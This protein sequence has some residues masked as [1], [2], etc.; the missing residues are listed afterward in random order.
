MRMRLPTSLKVALLAALLML[1]ANLAVIGFIRW[2]THD[3]SAALL[4]RQVAE[5]ASVLDDVYRTGGEAA[6]RRAI[7]DIL[8]ARDPQYVAAILGPGGRPL[9]GNVG[10]LIEPAERSAGFRDGRLVVVGAG[11]PVEAAF[12]LRPL[13]AG[14]WLLSG[15]SFGERLALQR[16]L[17]RSLLLALAIAVLLGLASG[18]VIARYVDRRVRGIALVADRIGHGDMSQRVPLSGSGDAFDGLAGQVNRMLDRIG[19]LMEELRLLTDCLAHD[20]RSPLGRLRAKV[21]AAIA[22]G[23]EGRRE[24]ALAGVVQEADSLMRILTT[25]LEIGRAEAMAPRNQFAWLDP[26]ELVAELAEMYEPI[27]EEAGASLILARDPVLLPLFGHRQL[28]AQ[29][30]SNL[31]DNALNYAPGG[32]LTL[33]ARA[34]EDSLSLGVA[35]RGPGIAPEDRAEARRQFGRLDEARAPGGAGLGLALVEAV[36]HLHQGRLALDDHVPGLVASLVLPIRS[37]AA[38]RSAPA[39]PAR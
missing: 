36:A 27:A 5:E 30:L 17:E 18:L 1:A 2:R 21:D 26:A 19:A 34:E 39:A 13:G 23:D 31:I 28:L 7:A 29:A 14:R 9:A 11:A 6:L 25:V 8:A 37:P 20:L 35:D 3:D 32:A 4:R 15:R 12:T 24:I 33:F 38:S 16:T 10:V 22:A